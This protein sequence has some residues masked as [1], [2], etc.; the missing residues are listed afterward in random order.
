[1]TTGEITQL[2]GVWLQAIAI[3]V[4]AFFAVRGLR[5][6]RTQMIGQRRFAVAE[7]TLMS[8]A[9]CKLVL[10]ETRFPGSSGHESEKIM[11]EEAIPEQ[12]RQRLAPYYTT[13]ARLR[14]GQDQFAK[15][16]S[17]QLAA[18]LHF[19]EEAHGAMQIL[20]EERAKVLTAAQ[21][22]IRDNRHE[23]TP[24]DPEHTRVMKALIWKS[25]GKN[26]DEV[27]TALDEA[28][29]KLARICE[30]YLRDTPIGAWF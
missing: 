21:M 1:M 10:E 7:D 27:Q 17:V 12:D 18:K 11:N 20:W 5:T 15:L 22:L 25:Y 26:D 30:P 16:A 19:G 9:S 3:S 14:R 2:A 8:F 6:W 13:L 23:H 29:K 28:E 4:T 24:Q